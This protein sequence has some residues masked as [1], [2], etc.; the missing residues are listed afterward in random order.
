MSSFTRT[1]GSVALTGVLALFAAS[2]NAQ[3]AASPA[4]GRNLQA[5]SCSNTIPTAAPKD[6]RQALANCTGDFFTPFD[7]ELMNFTIN[8]LERVT[9]TGRSTSPWRTLCI[10]QECADLLGDEAVATRVNEKMGFWGDFLTSWLKKQPL[11]MAACTAQADV[12]DFARNVTSQDQE[13]FR[14]KAAGDIIVAHMRGGN[15]IN[16]TG[17][18]VMIT[19]S[20]K[21]TQNFEYNSANP[22]APIPKGPVKEG[23][24]VS[25]CP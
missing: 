3:H 6:S 14:T 11:K 20:D 2:A 12:S 8:K 16:T 21:G 4:P 19:F 1:A 5:L 24:G 17:L 10:G 23:D 9:V 18:E 22:A 15:F 25:R 7:G 13:V